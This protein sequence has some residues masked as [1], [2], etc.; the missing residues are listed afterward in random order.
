MN[1]VL[2][3]LLYD[4]NSNLSFNQQTNSASA[5]CAAGQDILKD[6]ENMN[7][8]IEKMAREMQ[9][10]FQHAERCWSA[11]TKKVDML[12]DSVNTMT[13]LVHNNTLAL[14][15]QREEQVKKDLLGQLELSIVHTDLAI[16]HTS[17]PTKQTKL[18][19]KL[20]SLEQKW[21]AVRDK[22]DKMSSMIGNLQLNP[23]Q[24]SSTLLLTMSAPPGI[25]CNMLPPPT[26]SQAEVPQLLPTPTTTLAK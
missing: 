22:C 10:G 17:D 1:L 12:A 16:M 6:L 19:E 23:P 8:K 4:V 3:R 7:M 18:R 13:T 26:P 20:D 24:V 11:V 2:P 9:M 25:I 14:L 15:N 21:D 5:I